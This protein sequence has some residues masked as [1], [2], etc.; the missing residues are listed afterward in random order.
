MRKLTTD[1]FILKSKNIHGNLYDYKE[2]IYTKDINKVRIVCPLHGLFSIRPSAHISGQGCRLCGQK[3]INQSIRLT[4]KLFLEKAIIKYKNKYSYDLTGLIDHNSIIKVFCPKHGEFQ[5]PASRHLDRRDCK[6]CKKENQFIKGF[7]RTSYAK[8]V[9]G[10]KS[11]VYLAHFK[12]SE[13]QFYKIGIAVD[14]KDRFRRHK[15]DYK[16]SIVSTKEYY[17]GILTYNKEL[18]LHRKCKEFKYTPNQKFNGYTECYLLNP[19]IL[20]IFNS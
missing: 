16:V 6:I 7:G 4:P 2:V 5:C 1:G 11:Y 15:V 13:E 9:F 14:I 19:K 17:D 10:R 3:K 12:N 8:A 20:D 18:E